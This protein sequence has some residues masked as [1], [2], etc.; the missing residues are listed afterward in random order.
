MDLR[1][2]L[3]FPAPPNRVAAMLTDPTFQ[4]KLCSRS[5]RGSANVR[6]HGEHTHVRTTR[7]VATSSFPDFVRNLV[8]DVLEIEQR[9]VWGPAEARG[10]RRGE[11]TVRIDGT[12]LRLSAVAA[13]EPDAEGTLVTYDGKLTAAVPFIGGRIEKAAA[14]VIRSALE[15]EESLGREWLAQ[16]PG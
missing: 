3:S 1:V 7:I 6:M 5:G 10:H 4:E 15:A 12:P 13:M 11:V 14:P 8:G 16:Y 9:T 2:S